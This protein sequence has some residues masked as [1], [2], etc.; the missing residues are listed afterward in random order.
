[1]YSNAVKFVYAVFGIG[2]KDKNMKSFNIPDNEKNH[3]PPPHLF[4]NNLDVLCLREE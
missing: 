1:M 3:P 4:E 2:R